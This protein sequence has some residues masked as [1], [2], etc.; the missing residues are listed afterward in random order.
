MKH[1]TAL[2]RLFHTLPLRH[3]VNGN[4]RWLV[5]AHTVED[6]LIGFKTASNAGS[7]HG[8]DLNRVETGDV[9]AVRYH[10]TRAGNRFADQWDDGR[11]LGRDLNAEFEA[12]KLRRQMQQEVPQAEP[13]ARS[14]RL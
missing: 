2:L 12:M 7:A 13:V 11:S 1:Y 3:S 5:L 9:I 14:S 6:E 8:C 4:P 10:R